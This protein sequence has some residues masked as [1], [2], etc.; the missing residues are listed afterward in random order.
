MVTDEPTG[1]GAHSSAARGP[2]RRA[3]LLSGGIALVAGAG[4]G[5]GAELLRPKPAAKPAPQP[6]ALLVAAL[7]SERS[8]IASVDGS[9]ASSPMSRG[10]LTQIRADHVA[11]ERALLAALA[12][13]TSSNT[14]SPPPTQTSTPPALTDAQ[15]RSA[16]QA[17]SSLAAARARRT[18][19]RNATLLAS[20]A[21]CEATHAELLT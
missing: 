2:S 10:A 17:A 12:Q 7:A 13:A 9:L 16:E 4:G 14:P 20:I 15:L 6:P 21:A 8:L 3:F 5:V 19:G 1:T 11:H 18:S